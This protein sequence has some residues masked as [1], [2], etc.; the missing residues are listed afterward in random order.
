MKFYHESFSKGFPVNAQYI[1]NE[2]LFIKTAD[3]EQGF[4]PY[5]CCRPIFRRQS[6]KC[7]DNTEYSYELHDFELNKFQQIKSP[8][9][10]IPT[11]TPRTAKKIS[12]SANLSSPSY[13][14]KKP[15]LYKRRQDAASSSCGGDSGVSD[16]ESSTNNHYCSDLLSKHNT[17]LAN[18]QS[19]CSSSNTFKKTGFIVQDLQLEKSIKP[20]QIKSPLV[21]SS[22]SAFTQIVKKPP[23][24]ER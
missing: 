2:W 9:I 5:V 12:L 3:N 19:L 10:T 4:V 16:C 22:N 20:N 24:K 1:L 21:V 11:L 18:I 14:V 6:T 13:L 8:T 23:K 7:F 15:T 17:H